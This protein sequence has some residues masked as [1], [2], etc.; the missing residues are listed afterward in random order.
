MILRTPLVSFLILAVS[1]LSG[2]AQKPDKPNVLFIAIDDLKPLLGCYGDRLAKTP[3]IDRLA[4]MG[5]VFK[6]NYC[7]QAVCGPTRASIMTGMRPDVTKVWDL[8]TRMRDMNPDIL[9]IPQYFASQGYSTQAIGK[10]YDPRCVDEDLDKPSW[11]VPHYKTD[12]SYYAASTGQPVLN[13]YQAKDT[14]ALVEKQRRE[15]GEKTLT[16]Q[17]LPATIRPSMECVDVPDNAYIDGANSLQAKDI[18][19]ALQKKNRPFFFAV[20]LAKPHLPFNAPKK[21]WDLYE[22]DKMPVAAFQEQSKNAVDVA[23]QNSGE[24]RAYSDIP[25]LLAFTDQKSYGVTLPVARQKELLHGYYAAVSYADA[26]IGMVLNALD[27]L[28]LSKNTIVVLWGD[29]GWHLGD[30]NLWCKH[31]NFEEA[32]RSPLIFSAPHIKPSATQSLSEFVDV[33]PTLCELSGIPVP[34]HLEGK[35]LVPLMKN[36][37]A[38]VKEFA[39][40]QYP[41]SA[42][43]IETQRMTDATAKIMGYSMRT[44]RYRYTIWVEN[45]RTDQPFKASAVVGQELY[46]YAQDPLEKVNVLNDKKYAQTARHLK[47]E[48]IRYFKSKE[49]R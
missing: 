44:K 3:N 25:A 24:L 12:K 23:Y 1:G 33:F 46:D 11:T 18:L 5:T 47:A 36:P 17:M 37:G 20:G 6:S 10:I 49:K 9:T 40:S 28:G 31:S 16:D 27:S 13:Y 34:A 19:A 2:F 15:A 7:Q 41:R 45:F 32:T 14:R 48:M 22:R 43:A 4:K 39:V 8:K 21:Y 35:S 29:H 38:A 42:N 26:Q 30:H